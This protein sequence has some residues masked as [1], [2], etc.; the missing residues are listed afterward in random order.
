LWGVPYP[1]EMELA[2]SPSL[3]RVK[4][5]CTWRDS[6]YDDDFNGDAILELAAGL[7]PNLK[8]VTVVEFTA[9]RSGRDFRPRGSWQGLPGFTGETL[10]SLTSLSLNGLSLG[11]PEVLQRWARHTDFACLQH[12]TLDGDYKHTARSLNGETME[13]IAQ[14]HS[15]PRLRTLSVS[16][17]RDDAFHERPHYS[18]NAVSF[19]RAF[20]SLE[21]LS[22]HGPMDFHIMDTVL[23]HHGKTLRKLF[24]RPLEAS[25]N[26]ANG[27]DRR[28]IPMEFSKN[29]F[30]QIQAQCPVLEDLS[31]PVKR[32]RSSAS[33]AEMYRCFAEMRN[34]RCL[35]LILD[36]SNWR[37]SRDS[38]YN[39]Q[40]YGEDQELVNRYNSV[41]KG[42]VR[43]TFIN[44]AVDEALARSIWMTISQNKTGRQLERLKLW[45][46][47]GGEYGGEGLTS[48]SQDMVKVLSRSWLIERNLRDDQEGVTVRELGK[49]GREISDSSVSNSSESGAGQVF[50]TIWPCKEDSKD[51]RDDWSSFPLQV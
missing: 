31:I 40:F 41:K 5:Y 50:R 43:E 28:D 25:S 48:F 3:Y 49:R 12:L 21:E 18:E 51:W 22:I 15:F 34:L 13:W 7:A 8:E 45:T 36:C 38:T 29:D 10:G 14:N 47:G 32:N 17:N 33:E 2:T 27:R 24:L 23:S 30:L 4:L 46:T 37:I 6:D 9:Y 11:L 20:D 26:W 42:V 1:Y 44:C 35:F 39:P 19:F 16:M